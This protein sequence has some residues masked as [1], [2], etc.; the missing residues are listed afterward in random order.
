MEALERR[1]DK[2][3]RERNDAQKKLA[4]YVRMYE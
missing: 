3:E 4:E 2:A 1:L